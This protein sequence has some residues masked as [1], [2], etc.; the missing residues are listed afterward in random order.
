MMDKGMGMMDAMKEA[1]KRKKMQGLELSIEIEPKMGMEEE[2]ESGKGE[3]APESE[4]SKMMMKKDE[5][6]PKEEMP[7]LM[8]EGE[9]Y[10]ME[11][12]YQPKSIIERAKIAAQ[13]K[14]MK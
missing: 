4:A 1:L 5:M 13:K 11:E 9:E 10:M 8:E 3:L 7:D 12:G 6:M 14:K 2:M